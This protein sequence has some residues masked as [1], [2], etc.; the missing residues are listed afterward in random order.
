MPATYDVARDDI[1]GAFK[2]RWDADTPAIWGS[3]PDVRYEGVGQLAEPGP[4]VAWARVTIRHSQGR[5]ASLASDSGKRRFEKLGIV[6][7][8][9]FGPLVIAKGL[10]TGE[11]LAN[12]ALKAFEGKATTNG[13][14]FRNARITEVGVTRAWF[15]WNVI[16]EF[17]YDEFV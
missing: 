10:E 4:D 17:S 6:T 11:K 8:S 1:L 16:A 3:V 7:V 14:W 5:Q 12:V 13:V 2:T 15:M 9:V